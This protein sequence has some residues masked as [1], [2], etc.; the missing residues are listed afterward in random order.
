MFILLLVALLRAILTNQ[1]I[2]LDQMKSIFKTVQGLNSI[3]Q[4][5]TGIE[6]DLLPV[7]DVQTLQN[8]EERLGCSDFKNQLVS[9]SFELGC[10][11][12]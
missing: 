2:M 10:Q 7:S 3:A 11:K 6:Q 4:E 1:E 12:K 9:I 8:L 5:T